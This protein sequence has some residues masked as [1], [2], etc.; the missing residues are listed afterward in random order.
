MPGGFGVGPAGAKS[1]RDI[2]S[3]GVIGYFLSLFMHPTYIYT[4]ICQ[5]SFFRKYPMLSTKACRLASTIFS[6]TPTVL[7]SFLPSL[8][9]ISTRVLAAVPVAESRMRTL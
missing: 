7:H 2:G 5:A 4:P 1:L 3:G 9:S 6:L 8:D